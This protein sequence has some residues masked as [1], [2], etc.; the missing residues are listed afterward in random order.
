MERRERSLSPR[1]IGKPF[2]CIAICKDYIAICNLSR[3]IGT[4]RKSNINNNLHRFL[5]AAFAEIERRRKVCDPS[6]A[7]S[8]VSG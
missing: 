1:V 6:L 7:E 8:G 5:W 2:A 4:K 3:E